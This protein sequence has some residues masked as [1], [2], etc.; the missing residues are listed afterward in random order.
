M[1]DDVAWW[2]ENADRQRHHNMRIVT[3][4]ILLKSEYKVAVATKQALLLELLRVITV[5]KSGQ[6]SL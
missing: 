3:P 1:R 2:C 4:A 5:E 6:P